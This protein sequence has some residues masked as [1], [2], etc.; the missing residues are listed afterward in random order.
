MLKIDELLHDT[1]FISG[2]WVIARPLKSCFILRVK[3]AIQVLKG[4][5]DAVEFYKQ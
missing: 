1:T 4:K 2:K 5:A 3:D